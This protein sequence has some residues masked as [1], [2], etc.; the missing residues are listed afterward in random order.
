MMRL[1]IY[2]FLVVVLI[3]RIS[4]QTLTFSKQDWNNVREGEYLNFKV[5]CSDSIPVQ[6]FYLDGNEPEGMQLDNQGNFSWS[7]GYELVSATEK[8]K[9]IIVVFAARLMDDRTIR[10]E[11]TFTLHHTNQRPVVE[12]L[13]IFYVRQGLKNSYTI[14]SDYVMDPDGDALVFRPILNEMPEGMQ[15]TAGGV[16]TWTPGRSQFANLKNGAVIDFH[17]VD[18]PGR[19]ETLGKL[20][21]AQTQQD[22]PP[23]LILVPGDTVYSIKE[24]ESVSLKLY[25]SDPN[26]DENLARGGF[27]STDA[28]I[29][30]SIL[31][32][33][34]AQQSEFNWTPGYKF[35]DEAEK[36][37]LVE[38]TFYAIDKEANRVQKKIKIR[39]S[40]TENLDEKDKQTHQKYK[41]SLIAAKGLMDQLDQKHIELTRLY[42]QAKRGKKNRAIL[43]ASLGATTGLSPLIL[44]TESSKVISGI[45]GT[46][47]LTL[48]TLEATEVIGRS[49][50]DI[51]DQMNICVEIR[52]QLQ[53]EGDV[54][55]RKY[56]LKSERRK[57][58]FD[59]DREK[60]L[61]I[62]NNKKLLLLELDASQ[63]TTKIEGKELKKTFSDYSEEY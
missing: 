2:F 44:P 34:S 46:T 21:I 30:K 47:V 26:G 20:K 31:Q 19:L 39:I 40:D 8:K 9:D 16:I 58:E 61:P 13:P 56:A 33:T 15:L 48:G 11:A 32:E 22:L 41:A 17:V 55:A 28:R 24:D 43:N 6:H 29:P 36:S 27:V 53:I 25:F 18:Q 38:V 23:E 35:V 3:S 42:K 4:A 45:G 7:P 59:S 62:I 52:N 50:N 14:S 60:I 5:L 12:E 10:V 37:K 54:F 57:K 1:L 49:K 63:R 51:L